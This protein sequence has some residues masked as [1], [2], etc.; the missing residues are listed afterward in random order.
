MI[1]T[2]TEFKTNL[3][4]YLTLSAREDVLITKNG[5]GVAK[6]VGVHKGEETTLRSLRGILHGTDVTRKSIREERLAR[7]D[8][9]SD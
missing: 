8:K 4:K 1:V 5:R 7:Y 2:A 3:G 6:L 9:S